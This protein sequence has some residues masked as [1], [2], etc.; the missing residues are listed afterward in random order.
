MDIFNIK[1]T[2]VI[3][4]LFKYTIE[5]HTLRGDEIFSLSTLTT[6]QK[7]AVLKAFDQCGSEYLKSAFDALDGAVS[8]NDLKILR[9]YYWIKRRESPR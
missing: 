6:A 7:N 8:Y 4:H 5:G 2:T 1:Q 9:L 3:D